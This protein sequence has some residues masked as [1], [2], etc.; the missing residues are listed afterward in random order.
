MSNRPEDGAPPLRDARRV[1]ARKR[2]SRTESDS[3][4]TIQRIDRGAPHD[5]RGSAISRAHVGVDYAPRLPSCHAALT[6]SL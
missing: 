3:S 6:Y 2:A 1:L 5:P 4:L